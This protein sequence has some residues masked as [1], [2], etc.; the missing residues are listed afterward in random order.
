MPALF[1]LKVENG[2][3]KIK[4]YYTLA[5]TCR[6]RLLRTVFNIKRNG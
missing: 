1:K 6:V 3:L 4:F 5:L 2:K